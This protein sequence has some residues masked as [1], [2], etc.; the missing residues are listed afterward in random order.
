MLQQ[1]QK[2][3]QDALTV[4]TP[5]EIACAL[6][7]STPTVQRYADGTSSP[8]WTL[9]PAFQR[10]VERLVQDIY[11]CGSYMSDLLEPVDD[12]D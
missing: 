6:H 3:I 2:C 4:V 10:E 12:E 1:F 7:V 11:N 8:Y 9:I 5:L